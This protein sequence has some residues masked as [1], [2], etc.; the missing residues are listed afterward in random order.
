MG[1]FQYLKSLSSVMTQPM[2]YENKGIKPNC[3]K[4]PTKGPIGFLKT[5]LMISMSNWAPIFT[6]LTTTNTIIISVN[7][8]FSVRSFMPTTI[9]SVWRRVSLYQNSRFFSPI[10]SALTETVLAVD[11]L[12]YVPSRHVMMKPDP[13]S[14]PDICIIKSD[15]VCEESYRPGFIFLQ[16]ERDNERR[17]YLLVSGLQEQSD[18]EILLGV[19]GNVVIRLQ[20]YIP[21]E[22]RG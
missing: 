4:N 12:K 19:H 18:T 7:K 10:T 6:V 13:H 5:S 3:D 22:T 1:E 21:A 20:G 15:G 2:K 17:R 16:L 8:L 14:L 9:F 11:F